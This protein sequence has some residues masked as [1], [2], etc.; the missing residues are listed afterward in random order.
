MTPSEL[1]DYLKTMRD[2]GCMSAELLV[3]KPDPQD[4]TK[5]A[6]LVTIR[7]VF[8]PPE[9]EGFGTPIGSTDP[10][11]GGWKEPK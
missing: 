8:A 9:P 5:R 10:T 7:A 4:A 3:E 11:P 2:A 1:A 6:P